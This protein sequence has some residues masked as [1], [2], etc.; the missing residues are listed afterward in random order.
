M[1]ST[2]SSYPCSSRPRTTCRRDDSCPPA[3]TVTLAL[4]PVRG[5]K[6]ETITEEGRGPRMASHID[7]GGRRA[8]GCRSVHGMCLL[9]PER[10]SARPWAAGCEAAMRA[11]VARPTIRSPSYA[12]FTRALTGTPRRVRSRE[13]AASLDRVRACCADG[14]RTR[15]DTASASRSVGPTRL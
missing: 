1:I 9:V 7:G 8:R 5:R 2:P 15:A 6:S 10:A 3:A 14:P 13:S 11:S 4:M 12:F